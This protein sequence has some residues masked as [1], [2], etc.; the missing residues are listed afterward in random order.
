MHAVTPTASLVKKVGGADVSA[1]SCKFP[2]DK[3]RVLENQNFNF[4]HNF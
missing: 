4:A 3:I 1:D 2:I